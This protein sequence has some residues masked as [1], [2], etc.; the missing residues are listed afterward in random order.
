M[1]E[2]EWCDIQQRSPAGIEYGMHF[3]H[4]ATEAL[5]VYL[6]FDKIFTDLNYDL[7]CIL[8]LKQPTENQ[9]SF[10]SLPWTLKNRDEHFSLIDIL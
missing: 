3:N 7:D 9:S 5:L 1:E 10:W 2:R 8:V 6:F 4:L